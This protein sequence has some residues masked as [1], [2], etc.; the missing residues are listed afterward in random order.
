MQSLAAESVSQ[1]KRR[2]L[3]RSEEPRSTAQEEK[4][5]KKACIDEGEVDDVEE[6]EEGPET[7]VDGLL[8][9]GDEP[10][11]ASDP[12]EAHFA[13]PDDNVLSQRLK[14][15]Q[16]NH[17]SSRKAVLPGVGKIVMNLPEDNQSR[18][19]FALPTISG[20]GELKLKQKLAT[21]VSKQRPSFDDLEKYIAPLIFNYQ[22]IIFCER[23]PG[24][25]EALRRLTCL[26]A[27]NHVF[28]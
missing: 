23:T 8:E 28:K 18:G 10:E 5:S 4:G 27:V 3:D 25:G 19:I 17:W 9:D 26:H 12:F 2:K 20:P 6:A 16:N 1:A 7:A 15:I 14:S 24:N 22:D 21:L 13:E 11:D